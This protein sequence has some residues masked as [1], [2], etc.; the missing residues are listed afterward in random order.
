[1]TISDKICIIEERI[2]KACHRAGRKRSEITLLGVTK[3]QPA[4]F[5]EEAWKAGI[6][7]FGENRVQEALAKFG[8][9]RLNLKGIKLHMIGGL[10]RNKVKMAVGMFDCI[11]SVHNE[12]L[13]IE[14]A[15]HTIDREEPLNVLLEFRTGEDSKN[16]FDNLDGLLMAADKIGSFPQL[17]LS[18]F[19]TMA[20]NTSDERMIRR[21]FKQ[22]MNVKCEY[23]KRF[24]NNEANII[25]MGMSGDF[26]IA[27]EEGS[28]MLRIGSLIFGD[29]NDT[30]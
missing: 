13:I 3:F 10:Q 20:P 1:M 16:G 12:G 2:Q 28:T 21:A 22:L 26:E 7:F 24:P 23:T 6:R 15:K 18:G 27:I 11:Q 30:M 9:E 4:Q 14:L 29:S 5:I 25:S 8:K 17:K 19:M